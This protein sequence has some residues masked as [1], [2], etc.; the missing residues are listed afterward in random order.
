M[1]SEPL[2]LKIIVFRIFFLS[3]IWRIKFH[4]KQACN[5][6][7][8]FMNKMLNFCKFTQ[9]W[10]FGPNR[11]NFFCILSRIKFHFLWALNQLHAIILRP[12]IELIHIFLARFNRINRQE[13]LFFNQL[14]LV[15]SN[16][17]LQLVRSSYTSSGCGLA[18]VF[19]VKV[20]ECNLELG[21]FKIASQEVVISF[22]WILAGT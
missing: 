2:T 21:H 15:L 3:F 11:E 22:N 12:V 13:T 20:A 9:I 18:E 8:Q 10:K 19:Y 16:W 4:F 1:K 7:E 17:F 14:I 5:N 6:F